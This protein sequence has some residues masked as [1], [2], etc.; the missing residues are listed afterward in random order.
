VTLAVPQPTPATPERSPGVVEVALQYVPSEGG[1]QAIPTLYARWAYFPVFMRSLVDPAGKRLTVAG[2]HVAWGEALQD[3]SRVVLLAP[4][5]HGKTWLELCYVL[6][7]CW[8]HGLDP[9]TGERHDAGPW[10]AVLFGATMPGAL[11]LM[12]RLQELADANDAG[13]LGGITP[14]PGSQVKS[15]LR[16]VRSARHLR[17]HNGA[18]VQVRSFRG[19]GRGLHPDLVVGDD[20]LDEKNTSTS[21]Q[22]EKVWKRWIGEVEPMVNVGLGGQIVLVGTAFH[23]TDLLHRLKPTPDNDTGYA[24]LKFRALDEDAEGG[25]GK[26]LWARRHSVEELRKLRRRDAI[27]F[28]REYQNDPR[29]DASTLFPRKL[30]DPPILRGANL[31]YPDRYRKPLERAPSARSGE[32]VVLGG[33]SALSD[34]VG[35]DWFVLEV[36]R[37]DVATQERTLMWSMREQGVGLDEQVKAIGDACEHFGVDLGVVE[38]NA[39]QKW[40]HDRLRRDP[41]TASRVVGHNTGMEKSKLT[42]GVPSLVISLQNGLWTWAS[43]GTREK[44][45][46][47]TLQLEL[48]AFGW[49]D[50]KIGGVGEHDDT[51][52]ALWFVERGI[53][54]IDE[55]LAAMERGELGDQ[56][57]TGEEVGLKPVV[58]GADY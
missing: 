15:K 22:R 41:R 53:R 9:A 42:E 55:M 45:F 11:E 50:G 56:L 14:L 23:Y 3:Y 44:D 27:L 25:E 47:D 57:V 17:F 12:E 6:W 30:T 13:V 33:D 20:V 51:V 29:D 1:P 37:Y 35:A 39:F 18:D 10:R 28:A 32:F 58:I 24:W 54:M 16:A 5:D 38:G 26:A 49:K 2:H 21:Y 46:A 34:Q 4:R 7:R 52:M 8:R 19:S 43:K 40:L 36:A 48:G 31:S